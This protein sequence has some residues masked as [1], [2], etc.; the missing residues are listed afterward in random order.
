MIEECAQEIRTISYLLHPPLLDELGLAA[1]IR[2]YVEGFSKR[3]GVQV[4]FDTP[5]GLERFP[6]EVELTL[7]RIVQESLGNIHRHA[8][9]SNARICLACDAEQVMLEVSDP[10]RG[11]SG[12]TIRAIEAGRGSTGVGIAGMRERL[13]LLGG[14]LEIESGGQGTTVR[15]IIPRRQEPT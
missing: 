10:G 9:A 3:S 6:A 5:H 1:A 12:E 7:F 11:M 2:N 8:D 15:A 13:R 4:T 14:R